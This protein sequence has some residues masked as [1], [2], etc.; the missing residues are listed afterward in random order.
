MRDALERLPWVDHKSVEAD[1]ESKQV[2]FNVTDAKR[3]NVEELRGVLRDANFP[4]V[5]VLK[6]P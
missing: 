6:R 2:A 1:V 4:D 3:F 5:E